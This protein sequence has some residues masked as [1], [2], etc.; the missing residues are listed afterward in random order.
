M[1]GSL[2]KALPER[3]LLRG[4]LLRRCLAP[5]PPSP[6][7]SPPLTRSCTV[8]LTRGGASVTAMSPGGS[9]IWP[10][11]RG[12]SAIAA[13]SLLGRSHTVA[14]ATPA[15]LGRHGNIA[16]SVGLTPAAAANPPVPSQWGPVPPCGLRG[17]AVRPTDRAHRRT[18]AAVLP[19]VPGSTAPSLGAISTA[20]AASPGLLPAR[21][22]HVGL[23]RVGVPAVLPAVLLLLL[24]LLLPAGTR[25][26]PGADGRPGL[27]HRFLLLKPLDEV[28]G[29]LWREERADQEAD[30]TV[31][32]QAER[33]WPRDAGET[34]SCDYS[35]WPATFN[36]GYHI[37]WLPQNLLLLGGQVQVSRISPL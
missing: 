3:L 19:G 15:L 27:E 5:V 6:I 2:V 21:L 22:L 36:G 7:G 24:L 34:Q 26:C 28:Q 37:V 29:H 14:T 8:L 35:L 13:T 31:K 18:S 11:C 17:G 23:G 9:S 33:H 10:S 25:G 4:R 32:E 16:P 1:E 12:C 30:H 20:A